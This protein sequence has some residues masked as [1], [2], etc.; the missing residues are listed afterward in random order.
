[1][2]ITESNHICNNLVKIETLLTRSQAPKI[3]TANQEYKIIDVSYNSSTCFV[4]SLTL[5]D[6]AKYKV[7]QNKLLKTIYELNSL[8]IGQDVGRRYMWP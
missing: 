6:V 1:M 5:S 3:R 4:K 8:R 7:F 2:M